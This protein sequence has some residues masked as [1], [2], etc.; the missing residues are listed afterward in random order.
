MHGRYVVHVVQVL[1]L[2]DV[3][4]M[5]VV[6]GMKGVTGVY[7]FASGRLKRRGR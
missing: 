5:S 1:C 7:V 2:D 3:L 6:R 4:G